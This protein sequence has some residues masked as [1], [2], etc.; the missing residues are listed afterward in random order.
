MT[1]KTRRSLLRAVGIATIMAFGGCI[2]ENPPQKEPTQNSSN[3]SQSS[4][5][6]TTTNESTSTQSD[7]QQNSSA[8]SDQTT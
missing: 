1:S 3:E 5:N 4:T 2:T 8:G 7:L 6:Q